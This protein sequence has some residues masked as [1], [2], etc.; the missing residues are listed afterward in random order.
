MRKSLGTRDKRAL[1]IMAMVA[2]GFVILQ[3]GVLP[4]WDGAQEVRTQLPQKEQTVAKYRRLVAQSGERTAELARLDEELKKAET[5]L[6]QSSTDALAAAELERLVQG[7]AGAQQIELNSADFQKVDK[8]QGA[9]YAIP[10]AVQFQSRVDQLVN[11]L[12]AIQSAE[13]LLSVQKL[14]VQPAGGK[15]KRVMVTM[16]LSGWMRSSAVAEQ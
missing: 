9:Y 3:F 4:M 16:T 14:S 10:V 1:R 13:R 8:A 7:L 2:A 5:E 11:F 12:A 6:L 15:Q